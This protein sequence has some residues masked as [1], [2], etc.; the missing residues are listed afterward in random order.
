[1]TPLGYAHT[2][3]FCDG[4]MDDGSIVT[5]GGVQYS[6]LSV[7]SEGWEQTGEGKLPRPT[8]KLSNITGVFISIIQDYDDL[9]GAILTRRRTFYRYLDG[10]SNANPSA[11]F[12][13]DRYI[14]DRKSKQN[15]Y[16]LEFELVSEI[17][18]EN[19]YLPKK[20]A[21]SICTHRYRY[22]VDGAFVD[23]STNPDDITC[24]YVGGSYFD[25]AGASVVD[26]ADDI[27]GRRLFDCKLRFPQVGASKPALPYEGFPNIRR[28]SR[29]R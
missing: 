10:Q 25:E 12:P 15:K 20:Q 13:I 3:S 22:Y 26:P 18:I 29:N 28:F 19:V 5:F 11:Q 16:E 23:Y 9:V 7:T 6:P 4:V 17:D 1:M 2:Y 8:I 14:I 27:C 21:M 24:P